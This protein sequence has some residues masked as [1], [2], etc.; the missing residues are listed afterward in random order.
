MGDDFVWLAALLGLA[1]LALL[2]IGLL[3]DADGETRS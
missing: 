3:G 2:L 1:L